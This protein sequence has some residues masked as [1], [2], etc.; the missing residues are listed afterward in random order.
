[1]VP[2]Y[3]P[4]GKAEG[5]YLEL[6]NDNGRYVYVRHDLIVANALGKGHK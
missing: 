2:G 4:E 3:D 1:V 6:L 5:A